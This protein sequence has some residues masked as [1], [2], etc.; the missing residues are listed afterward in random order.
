M[1][2]KLL[3][4]LLWFY[5]LI[6]KSKPATPKPSYYDGS[7]QLSPREKQTLAYIVLSKH[8][9]REHYNIYNSDGY[10]FVLNLTNNHIIMVFYDNQFIV[11]TE[12]T[13]EDKA[14]ALTLKE[15]LDKHFNDLSLQNDAFILDLD[16]RAIYIGKAARD[17]KQS[18]TGAMS[19][20]RVL[21]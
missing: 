21:H 11:N 16:S 20:E 2:K 12:A 5:T 3:T 10:L 18:V 7:A 8:L 1:L 13:D 6:F 4:I 17:Y 15:V 9:D 14:F 19:E